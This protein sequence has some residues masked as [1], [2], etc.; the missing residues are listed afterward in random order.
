M[1]RIA[2]NH[3][4]DMLDLWASNQGWWMIISVVSNG[5]TAMGPRFRNNSMLRS[6][7]ASIGRNKEGYNLISYIWLMSSKNLSVMTVVIV[8]SDIRMMT[9]YFFLPFKKKYFFIKIYW[10]N[11][12]TWYNT[13]M[14]NINGF[15]YL[16]LLNVEKL[17]INRSLELLVISYR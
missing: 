6:D 9:L 15:Y 16:Y 5:I 14:T 4:Y 1:S 10:L 12:L 13:I 3:F 8:F 11:S 17:N 2:S 7:S